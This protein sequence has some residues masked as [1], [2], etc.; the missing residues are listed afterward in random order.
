MFVWPYFRL[1]ETWNWSYH[2]LDVFAKKVPAREFA[3]T[4]VD[5]FDK[6]DNSLLAKS[7]LWL[8]QRVVRHLSHLFWQGSGIRPN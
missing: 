3:T 4:V 5:P 1:P 8:T 7:M 2:E 6:Q